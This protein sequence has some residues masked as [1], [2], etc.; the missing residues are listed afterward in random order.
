METDPSGAQKAHTTRKS[1]VGKTGKIR[2]VLR[3]SRLPADLG[4]GLL[5]ALAAEGREALL[6]HFL[7]HRA[8]RL[9]ANRKILAPGHRASAVGLILGHGD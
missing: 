9:V 5:A 2:A 8:E 3:G 4:F 6:L 7:L 1:N